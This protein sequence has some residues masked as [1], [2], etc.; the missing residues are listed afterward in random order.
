MNR[1]EQEKLERAQRKNNP[2]DEPT[3]DFTGRCKRCG[4]NDL[5]DDASAY[6]CNSCGAIVIHG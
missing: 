1:Q 2:N 5:W 3:G 4:S 6:G